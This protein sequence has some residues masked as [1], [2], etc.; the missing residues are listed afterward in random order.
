MNRVLERLAIL[1]LCITGFAIQDGYTEPVAVGLG[2]VVV[3]IVVQLLS[4]TWMAAVLLF[5]VCGVA[6]WIPMVFCAL[7]LLMYEALWEK[8]WYL[9]LPSLLVFRNGVDALLP[10]QYVIALAGA[11]VA[12]LLY[13]VTSR[14]EEAAERFHTLRD[15]LAEKNEMLASQNERLTEAQNN[16]VHLATLR[17]RNRIA[18]EIH[19]NVG[20]MLTRSLLQSGALLVA[21][22]DEKLR[23][24]LEE[25]RDTL[26]QAMTSIRE[27]VHDL[28]DE[29]IDLQAVIQ[30][31]LRTAEH[32]FQTE[33]TY[34]V[35]DT[36]PSTVKLCMAGVV[37]EAVSN[38]VKHSNGDTLSVRLGEKPGV[39]ELEIRDNGSNARIGGTGIG[40]SN[41]R[42]RVEEVRGSI[43]FDAS[44][45]GF[46]VIVGVPK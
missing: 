21:N 26:D 5:V 22:K 39:Y 35:G 38:A 43:R 25:L 12:F 41:M 44:A 27:S 14:S 36:M 30:D 46:T 33:L 20:H 17:E 7:P 2:L 32:L 11:G 42:E 8:K 10:A 23:E 15:E 45:S 28:H 1:I 19:D 6:G 18:R 24:P 16:E 40:L 31:H 34:T 29:S 4:G 37:K 9:V 3:S 13:L